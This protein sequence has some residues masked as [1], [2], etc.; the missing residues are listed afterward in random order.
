MGPR[1]ALILA[2]GA[3]AALAIAAAAAALLYSKASSLDAQLAAAKTQLAQL[4]KQLSDARK[5]LNN[6][7][8]ELAAALNRNKL[9]SANITRL[10]QLLQ[11]CR[12]NA[13]TLAQ[14]LHSLEQRYSTLLAKDKALRENYTKLLNEYRGLEAEYKALE[15]N[16]TRLLSS[17]K[18]LKEKY[19]SLQENHTKLLSLYKSLRE[20]YQSL[21]TRYNSLNADYQETLSRLNQLQDRLLTA[22]QE[23][24]E[25]HTKL[26]SLNATLARLNTSIIEADEWLGVYPNETAEA[27]FIEELLNESLLIG[28]KFQDILGLT[29]NIEDLALRVAELVEVNLTA[30]APDPAVRYVDPSTATVNISDQVWSTPLDTLLQGAGDCEDQALLAYGVIAAAA[31]P[32][33]RVYLVL[34]Y[35]GGEGHAAVL[36]DA[37]APGGTRQYI[38]LDPAGNYVNGAKLVLEM[39]MKANNTWWYVYTSPQNIAASTKLWLIKN[40]FAKIVYRDAFTRRYSD[41]P[42]T[43]MRTYTDPFQALHDWIVKYWGLPGVDRIVLATPTEYHAFTSITDAAHWLETTS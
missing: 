15:A 27:E 8:S 17:Y 31:R 41:N 2:A 21:L 10:T 40:R 24:A 42:A 38:V 20:N 19:T 28:K 29:G 39:E 12:R 22:E 18:A 1:G 4:S 37:P 30:Y 23:N 33:T 25:L 43:I 16:Y 14:K 3:L 6:C 9:L 34:I 5:S 32:G 13:T 35:S 7:R 36:V 26:E 11:S